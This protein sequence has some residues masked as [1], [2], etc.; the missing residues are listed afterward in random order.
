[1]MVREVEEDA[2][3][4]WSNVVLRDEW[5]VGGGCLGNREGSLVVV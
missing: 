5:V 2:K 3:A 1:M 4:L